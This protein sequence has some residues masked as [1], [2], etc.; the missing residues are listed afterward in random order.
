MVKVLGRWGFE[1][2]FTVQLQLK[3]CHLYC[4]NHYATETC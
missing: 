3:Y 2:G 4:S 1:L